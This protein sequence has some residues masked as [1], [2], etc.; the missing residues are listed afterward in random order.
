MIELEQRDIPSLIK[1]LEEDRRNIFF[2]NALEKGNLGSYLKVYKIDEAYILH[3][4]CAFVCIYAQGE[5][6]K[7]RLIKFLSSLP[8]SYLYELE[9][10]I[11]DLEDYLS[12][13]FNVEKRAMMSVDKSSFIRL[14]E[15]DT[16]LRELFAPEDYEDLYDMYTHN[17][18]FEHDY[19]IENKEEW[20]LE[21]A[22]LEYPHTGVGLYYKNRI[23]SGAYLLGANKT[24]AAIVGVATDDDYVGCGFATSVVSELVDIALYENNINYLCLWYNNEKAHHIYS[25]LGFMPVGNYIFAKRK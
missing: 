14:A 21:K 16:R 1:V 23:I 13:D 5:Y 9:E 3:G 2:L 7:A 10:Q 20:A 18:E 17:S 22:E 12:K 11:K 19:P 8:F 6:D 4:M 24:R 25:K 15:R